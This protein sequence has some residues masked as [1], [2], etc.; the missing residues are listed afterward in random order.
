MCGYGTTLLPTTHTVGVTP[1][2][3]PLFCAPPPQALL[4]LPT[5][6]SFSPSAVSTLARSGSVPGFSVPSTTT[7][8]SLA[9]RGVGRLNSVASVRGAD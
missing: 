5:M 8:C 7:A 3:R 2:A 4:K 9:G 1:T 6:T